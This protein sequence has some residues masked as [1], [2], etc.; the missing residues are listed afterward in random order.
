M[1]PFPLGD[2]RKAAGCRF[3]ASVSVIYQ[4]CGV[5]VLFA[6]LRLECVFLVLFA[7]PSVVCIVVHTDEGSGAMKQFGTICKA[8]LSGN[9]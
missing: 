7:H 2:Y 9:K 8:S 1:L 3:A 5:R 6:A 4:V